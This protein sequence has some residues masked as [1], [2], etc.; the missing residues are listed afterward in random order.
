MAVKT[1]DLAALNDELQ[2]DCQNGRTEAGA[3]F[4]LA[5]TWVGT[6]TFEATVDGTNWVEVLAVNANDDTA[7]TTATANG[8]YRVIADGM[9]VRARVSAYTSGTVEAAGFVARSGS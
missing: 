5:G 8:I 3:V 2:L 7:A 9:K 4:Q 6:I 1:A